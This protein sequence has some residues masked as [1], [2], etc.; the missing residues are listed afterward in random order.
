MVM[1]IGEGRKDMKDKV[2]KILVS[3][4]I[5]MLL[6]VP[7]VAAWDVPT[8]PGHVADSLWLEPVTTTLDTSYVS[9]G[10]TFVVTVYLNATGFAIAGWAFKLEYDNT[11]LDC[12]DAS[13]SGTG[14]A[15]S[16]LFE[17]AGAAGNPAL[18]PTYGS[19]YVLFGE[20]VAGGPTQK[21]PNGTHC[22]SSVAYV[23]FNVT[24]VPIK[25]EATYYSALN[26]SKFFGVQ[27]P[28]DFIYDSTVTDQLDAVFD[29]NA[30]LAWV[31][32]PKA[33]F[34]TVPAYKE[35][36]QYT[37]AI[38]QVFDVDIN[39]AGYYAS[40]GMTNATFHLGYDPAIITADLVTIN[41]GEWNLV[42]LN[43]D[44]VNGFVNVTVDSF[45]GSEDNTSVPV[46]TIKFRVL[47]QMDAPPA[48][49]GSYNE[50]A[51]HFDVSEIWDH[52]YRI[53][54]DPVDGL[55]RIYAYQAL[56]L[57]YL[58]V[59]PN[60]II[61]GPAPAL[62]EEFDVNIDI[63]NL[64][65]AWYLVGLDFRLS[66][67]PSL[68]SVVE[69]VEGPYLPQF[70]QSVTPMPTIFIAFDEGTYITGMDLI[71]PNETGQYPAP[72]AGADPPENGTI[73]IIT[74]K[75]MA[76]D[77]A[78]TP[79]NYTCGLNL[80]DIM[81]VD[82]ADGQVP[83][84]A[85]ENATYLI[86]GSFEVGRWI[87]VFTQYPAPFGG[88][89]LNQPSDMFWPQKEVCLTAYV[90]Y[91]CWPLQNKLVTFTVYDNQGS[92][93]TQL[94][95][96]TNTTGYAYVCF[97]MPWP[98]EDPESLFGVWSVTAD[99]DI[100]CVVINDTVEFHYDYLINIVKVTT[101][102]YYYNH[103]EYVNVHVEFTSH[104]QQT[105]N[106]SLTVT[107]HDNLNYPIATQTIEFTIGGATFCTP[108]EYEKDFS[109]HILKFASAGEAIVFA[110]S[111]LLWNGVWTA[112]GP[113]AMTTI[114]IL[115]S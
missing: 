5:A 6:A 72:V 32:P 22:P 77:N 63:C 81:M 17:K 94:T 89:G 68:L 91:N 86:Y 28:E 99:V 44:T 20:A 56:T 82:K 37:H 113:M 21:Y 23:T 114:Y 46:A 9:A 70:N 88:Q 57:P 61:F 111:R 10:Y 42:S 12:I 74:F 27:S 40:W 30:T 50:T 102:K 19:N 39:I 93:W 65:F 66:Y 43:N 35:Y 60:S 97:R 112:A 69:V 41:T 51:L 18:L 25:G 101:D 54:K 31:A 105:Y 110:T 24:K 75:V 67:D 48:P 16:Q 47:V 71:L 55:V 79:E 100:A 34:V 1:K 104:A 8:P 98:C 108:K 53:D 92:V 87:D 2:S 90:A 84:A 76:Q 95:A 14:G 59:K 15:K 83:Y 29:A 13:W 78:C 52:Q 109:L 3:L 62:G 80:Y 26:M 7:I 115:P 103:C 49:S 36:D 11:W 85:P 64:H 96:P 106:V 73:A 58:A 4:L 45:S 33:K 107:I 38:G